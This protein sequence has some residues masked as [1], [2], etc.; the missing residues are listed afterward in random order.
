MRSTSSLAVGSNPVSDASPGVPSTCVHTPSAVNRRTTCAPS[1]AIQTAPSGATVIPCGFV[2]RMSSPQ[3]EMNSPD[4]SYTKTRGSLRVSRN[5]RSVASMATSETS[6]WTMPCGSF[7]QPTTGSNAAELVVPISVNLCSRLFDASSF[8][9]LLRLSGE[10]VSAFGRRR[11]GSLRARRHPKARFRTG[12]SCTSGPASRVHGTDG[13]RVGRPRRARLADVCFPRCARA[14]A[15]ARR[16]GRRTGS[17][18]GIPS[19][20]A[21]RLARRLPRDP[22]PACPSG[23]LPPRSRRR[24]G[25]HRRA[26]GDAHIGAWRARGQRG[27][28]DGSRRRDRR[29]RGPRRRSDRGGWSSGVVALGHAAVGQESHGSR[30]G[31]RA[32][33]L[34]RSAGRT[35]DLAVADAT[36]ICFVPLAL[37]EEVASR[38]LEVAA[39][40][41]DAVDAGSK[42]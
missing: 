9:P 3:D 16:I 15:S 29:R 24:R 35:G 36:G 8:A 5:T 18:A 6:R 37:V 33:S 17:D 25:R 32:R 21:A 38:V 19:V 22:I 1:S 40:E 42:K 26:R 30:L 2:L 4:R 12:R 10:L 27:C 31:E 13:H 7:S 23:S 28:A 41:S 11:S 20:A 39:E 14:A 34:W